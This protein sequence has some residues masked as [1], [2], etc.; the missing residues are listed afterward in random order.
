MADETVVVM[1]A[2]GHVGGRVA[3]RL[4][5]AGARVRVVGRQADRLAGWAARGAEVLAG[6][7]NEAAFAAR[8]L[9]GAKA[10]FLM[11]PPDYQAED[12]YAS[13]QRMVDALVAGVRAA[14]VTHVVSLSSVGAHLTERTGPIL[15]LRRFEQA[16]DAVDG[17]HAVHLR[18]AYFMENHLTVMPGI[19]FLNVYASPLRADLPMA[20]IA[21]RDIGDVAA[22]LLQRRAF[23]GHAVRELLGPCDVTMPEVARLLGAAIG[24][25]NLRYQRVPYEMA[26]MAFRQMGI[27]AHVATL[28]IEMTRGL[29]EGWIRPQETRSPDNTTPTPLEAFAAADFATAWRGNR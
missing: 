2:T 29:N 25:P 20:Q 12:G 21:A 9:A 5:E 22:G 11:V 13:Q 28:F 15:G 6:S 14:G 1:G 3:D 4:C 17:L 19:R 8:A 24:K 18:P 16:L 26:E 7:M 23:C 10:A 27:S